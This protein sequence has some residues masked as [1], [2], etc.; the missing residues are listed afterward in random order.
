MDIK[1]A[2]ILISIKS[3]NSS[4]HLFMTD[5]GISRI[6][7]DPEQS[8]TDGA[9]GRMYCSPEVADGEPRGRAPDIFNL[10][11]AFAEVLTCIAGQTVQEFRNR[12]TDDGVSFHSNLS[13][14]SNGLKNWILRKGPPYLLLHVNLQLCVGKRR[15]T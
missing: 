10:G 9:T 5:F 8:Q 7:R 1:P 6:I 15:W 13:L 11:C 2:N 14:W 4:I 12:R 3:R